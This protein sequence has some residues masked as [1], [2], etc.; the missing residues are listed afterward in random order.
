MNESLINPSAHRLPQIASI[1]RGAGFKFQKQPSIGVLI[2]KSS[3][4]MQQ[5]YRRKPMP[6]FDFNKVAKQS[7]FGIAILL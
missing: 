5:I 3:E 6:K 4:N 1:K 2:K 7:H